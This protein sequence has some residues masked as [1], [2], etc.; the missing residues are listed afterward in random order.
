MGC[1]IVS[2][3]YK[4]ID[5]WFEPGKELFVVDTFDECIE[6]YKMLLDDEELRLKTGINARNRVLKEHTTKHRAK[7]ISSIISKHL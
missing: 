3:P 4:G 1:C 2:S 7:Q 6:M 5:R